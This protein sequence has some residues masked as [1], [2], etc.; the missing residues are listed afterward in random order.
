MHDKKKSDLTKG[1]L[2]LSQ[3]YP[4]LSQGNT[5]Q[6]NGQQNQ[7]KT[8]SPKPTSLLL[9]HVQKVVAQVLLFSVVS[10]AQQ[11]TTMLNHAQQ[12]RRHMKFQANVVPMIA[13]KSLDSINLV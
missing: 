3:T 2:L 8:N 13:S 12:L 4:Y 1:S 6:L 11:F 9:N 7:E 5:N 10:D